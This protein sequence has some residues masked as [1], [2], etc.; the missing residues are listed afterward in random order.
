MLLLRNLVVIDVG[1]RR[2]THVGIAGVDAIQVSATGVVAGHINFSRTEREPA[3]VAA[4]AGTDIETR[5][6]APPMKATSAG[7]YT[8]W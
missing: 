8:G 5:K 3:H 6:F 7:A 2:V 4:S 1:Y